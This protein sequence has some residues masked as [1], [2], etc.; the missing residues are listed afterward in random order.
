[1][2]Y[3]CVTLI[4]WLMFVGMGI[5]DTAGNYGLTTVEMDDL[6]EETATKK[7]NEKEYEEK[8]DRKKKVQLKG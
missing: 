4:H 5:S 7:D 1:M 6:K 3:V 2:C 8:Q